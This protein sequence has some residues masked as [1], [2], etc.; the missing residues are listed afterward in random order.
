MLA[1]A[2]APHSPVDTTTDE[3]VKHPIE[4]Y[5][6]IRATGRFVY[7]PAA[8]GFLLT[9]YRDVAALL[10]NQTFHA[11]HYPAPW[12]KIGDAVH[13]DFSA[14]IALLSYMPFAHEGP[15]HDA[16]RTAMAQGVAPIAGG[17]PAIHA[18]IVAALQRARRDGGFDLANDFAC[19][20]LFEI[21]C[22][23]ME[24]PHDDRSELR[25][26]AT[27]SWGVESTITAK[28][29]EYVSS[30]T[31]R[32]IDYLRAHAATK[33]S[34][35]NGGL[36]RDIHD[37][38]PDDESDKLWSTAV[39]AT[40]MLVMGN[41][42]LGACISMG[43]RRLLDPQYPDPVPQEQWADVA[44]DCIRYSSPV[45]YVIRRATEDAVVAGCPV[46][47]GE[48]V[49]SSMLAAN[50]DPE[51]YGDQTELLR[52]RTNVGLAFGAGRHLCVGSRLTRTVVKSAFAALAGLPELRL[53]GEVVHGRGKLVRVLASL[54]VEFV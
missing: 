36:L 13:R 11:L 8:R 17:N 25:P 27:L 21:M 30:H 51:Q 43:A 4:N 10:R 5:E 44:N 52:P 6:R 16:L 46:T 3:F 53:A 45:D 28:E 12:R 2:R 22:D 24:I 29:R 41:D 14:A 50:H 48:Y 7:L 39:L 40:V 9:G 54:P 49:F 19:H 26:M 15:R 20:L 42:A 38:L 31:S 33:V 18:S 23:I 37:A 35:S 32:C 47:K 34:G 1:E